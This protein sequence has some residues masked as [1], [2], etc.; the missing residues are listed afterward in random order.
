V[1]IKRM[2][3][4]QVIELLQQ[5]PDDL[6]VVVQGY[7]E[8]YDPVTDVGELT[9][10]AKQHREWYVGVY[11]QSDQQGEKVVAISSKYNRTELDKSGSLPP[12]EEG[13][14]QTE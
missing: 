7:E 2:T 9:V 14:E 3:V 4:R 10:A 1:T 12:G 11:E 5:Y 8:G 13:G 6:P